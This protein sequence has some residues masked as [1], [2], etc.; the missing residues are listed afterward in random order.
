MDTYQLDRVQTLRVRVVEF[1]RSTQSEE[2]ALLVSSSVRM[3]QD[4][5]QYGYPIKDFVCCPHHLKNCTPTLL[6]ATCRHV[7]D[8]E[9]N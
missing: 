6:L 7:Q 2:N 8:I 9:P 5:E 4:R 3:R 1:Y